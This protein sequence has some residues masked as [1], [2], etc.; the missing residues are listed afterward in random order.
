MVKLLKDHIIIYYHLLFCFCFSGTERL[1]IN[2]LNQTIDQYHLL[3]SQ[4]SIQMPDHHRSRQWILFVHQRLLEFGCCP[5]GHAKMIAVLPVDA[6]TA[7][8]SVNL[9]PPTSGGSRCS[10]ANTHCCCVSQLMLQ[11]L[12]SSPLKRPLHR[13]VT[14]T[15][16]HSQ[17]LPPPLQSCFPLHIGRVWLLSADARL[18]MCLSFCLLRIMLTGSICPECGQSS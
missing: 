2:H 5:F 9:L 18:F 14:G 4:N 17:N 3:Y 8:D 7:M 10:S 16:E 13:G 15:R 12:T 6:T 11:F 1:L